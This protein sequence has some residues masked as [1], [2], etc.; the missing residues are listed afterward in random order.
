MYKR[1]RLLRR[2]KRGIKSISKIAALF[3]KPTSTLAKIK[4]IKIWTNPKSKSKILY[5][6]SHFLHL[7]WETYWHEITR[8]IPLSNINLEH[9]GFTFAKLKTGTG[10]NSNREQDGKKGA[11]IMTVWRKCFPT[12]AP[13]DWLLILRAGEGSADRK[14]VTPPFFSCSPAEG[15]FGT[16]HTGAPSTG[17][18]KTKTKKQRKNQSGLLTLDSPQW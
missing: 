17:R 1:S 4:L 9:N 18:K 8:F 10:Q 6:T 5:I 2:R 7:A 3:L 16:V 12:S 13:R 14:G 15:D 11:I